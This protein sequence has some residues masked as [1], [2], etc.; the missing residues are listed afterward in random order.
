VV[1]DKEGKQMLLEKTDEAWQLNQKY[2]A[3]EQF[4][5]EILQVINTMYAFAPLA[6][7]AQENAIKQ[8]SM[9]YN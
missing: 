3:N 2:R 4:V 7:V 6:N 8:M 5:R 9:A 1:K